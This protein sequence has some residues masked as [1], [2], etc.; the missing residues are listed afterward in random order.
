MVFDIWRLK[1]KN[2]QMAPQI[3][4]PLS[5]EIATRERNGEI[6]EKINS[7]IFLE[8]VLTCMKFL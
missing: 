2:E 5:W 3:Y 6:K 8:N 1:W 4:K 7:T